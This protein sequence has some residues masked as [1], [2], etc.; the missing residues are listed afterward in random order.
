M[1][2]YVMKN[3]LERT[4]MNKKD[5]LDFILNTVNDKGY[6]STKDISKKLKVSDMTARRY[7]NELDE[8]KELIKVHGGAESKLLR[9][10]KS[11]SEKQFLHIDE[12][13]YLAKI[14]ANFIKSGD[15]VFI[16]SGT[17]LEQLANKI[18]DEDIRV[19][20]NSWPVFSIL[21]QRNF[22]EL[23]LIGGVFRDNTG[24]FVGRIATNA[25]ETMQ[26]SKVFVSCNGI[27]NSS[28][29]TFT[30]SAGEVQTIALNQAQERFLLADSSKFN[31][32]DFYQFYDL[33]NIDYL[34][35]DPNIDD[36]VRKHY[37]K[38]TKI[39]TEQNSSR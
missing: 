18:I 28:I 9:F 22:K 3:I 30:E 21:N 23:I 39:L 24:A 26:F 14:A 29:S 12:K 25:L 8:K 37:S 6:I 11:Q 4:N 2:I 19:V 5:K 16:G 36:K 7:L 13:N 31:K 20:T 32:I 15:T 38:F 35:T 34:I 10:E 17:T 33:N 27:Y 1:L